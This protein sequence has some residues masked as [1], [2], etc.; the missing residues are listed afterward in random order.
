MKKEQPTREKILDVVYALVYIHGYNGTSMSMILKECAIPKGSL[1]HFFKS[2]KEMVLAVL[3]ERIAPSVY[4][5][6]ALK[7]KE[8]EKGLEVVIGSILKTADNERVI[9]YGCPLNRLNQEMSPV[10]PDFENEI[11]VIYNTI[12]RSIVLTLE[13]DTFKEN[14]EL[15]SLADYV[16]LSVWGA[17]SVPP[18]ESSKERY[19]A[20]VSHTINYLKSLQK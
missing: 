18:K 1:Y 17:L 7:T 6:H 4:A 8:D 2:K 3:K 9:T 20:S 11:I 16:I 15:A 19:L 14:I 13:Q 12:K 5:F 10:D